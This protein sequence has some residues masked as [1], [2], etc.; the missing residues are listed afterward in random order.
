[1]T[2]SISS[3]FFSIFCSESESCGGGGG[4]WGGSTGGRA[5]GGP[6]AAVGG[7][8]VELLSVDEPPRH[9]SKFHSHPDNH[10]AT[11]QALNTLLCQQKYVQQFHCCVLK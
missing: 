11:Q 4:G 8:G 1:M 9:H 2:F 10:L 7:D 6:L 5:A 3:I